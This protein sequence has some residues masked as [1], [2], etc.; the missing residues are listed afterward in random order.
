M[1]HV[2]PPIVLHVF[3]R[4]T[5]PRLASLPVEAWEWAVRTAASGAYRRN[6]PN[7]RTGMD[8]DTSKLGTRLT[9]GRDEIS[10]SA[11]IVL[12]FRLNS[13]GKSVEVHFGQC[14]RP[15]HWLKRFHLVIR[16][17]KY[18]F[19]LLFCDAVKLFVS[20]DEAVIESHDISSEDRQG[21]TSFFGKNMAKLFDATWIAGSLNAN[22]DS[23]CDHMTS[24]TSMTSM[25]LLAPPKTPQPPPKERVKF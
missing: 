7:R 10:T 20:V 3:Y 5:R 22:L 2:D 13:N 18:V 17:G 15:C 9:D 12:F 8:W 16:W 11:M 21:M 25:T 24:M 19:F 14:T 23:F 1:A 4:P 6:R